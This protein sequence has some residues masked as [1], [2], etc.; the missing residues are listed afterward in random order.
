MAGLAGANIAHAREHFLAQT[1]PFKSVTLISDLHSACLGA[2]DGA[3]GG[4]IICGTGS[5]ATAYV[6][7]EFKDKGGYGIYVGDNASGA[8]LGL[9]AIKHCLF[10]F[11]GLADE[12]LVSEKICT[13]LKVESPQHLVSK[14]A[15]YKGAQFGELAPH[16]V[17]AFRLNCPVATELLQKGA[18]YLSALANQIS[19]HKN[20]RLCLVGGLSDVYKPLLAPSVY[21]QL[22]TPEHTAQYGVIRYAKQQLGTLLCS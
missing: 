22:C 7:G 2:H 14:T 12:S 10:V 13:A 4:L 5:A 16:V 15:S 20:Q 6:N 8:W 19:Y 3:D 17:S 1:H 9:E 21:A 18:A 11:D